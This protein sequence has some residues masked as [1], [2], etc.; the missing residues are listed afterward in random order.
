MSTYG[1]TPKH[2]NNIPCVGRG[3]KET[4]LLKQS[5]SVSTNFCCTC[6]FIIQL[7]VKLLRGNFSLFLIFC[8]FLVYHFD[9]GRLL[10]RTP[11]PVPLGL[12]CVLLVETEL[13]VILPDYAL[14]ISLGTFSILLCQL[15]C[16]YQLYM[17]KFHTPQRLPLLWF[18][19]F[20]NFTSTFPVVSLPLFANDLTKT[21]ILWKENQKYK[22]IPAILKE[23]FVRLMLFEVISLKMYSSLERTY[24]KTAN[25]IISYIRFREKIEQYS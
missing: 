15:Y 23:I 5:T 2:W 9:R 20:Q 18:L 7:A 8:A 16:P 25:W 11:G 6:C 3:N 24:N 22:Q 12:A 1:G 13:V 14:R 17:F 10:L 4:V 19:A 21:I